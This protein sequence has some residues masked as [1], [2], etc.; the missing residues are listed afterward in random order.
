MLKSSSPGKKISTGVFLLGGIALFGLAVLFFLNG[1]KEK[2]IDVQEKDI[3]G[4][5]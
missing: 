3:S 2:A 4:S 1:K 5:Q